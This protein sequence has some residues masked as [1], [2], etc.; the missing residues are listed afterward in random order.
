MNDPFSILGVAET[1]TPD[2]I[3]KKYRRLAQKYH[4]DRNKDVD[5][6]SKFK[7]VNEAYDTLSNDK[8]RQDYL[9][10]R[11]KAETKNRY[12]HSFADDEEESI[13]DIFRKFRDSQQ[14]SKQYATITL[15]Q[16][17]KGAFLKVSG[18]TY[19]VSPGT[20][21]GTKYQVKGKLVEII[22]MAH[23]KFKRSEND[24]LVDVTLSIAEAVLGID[25]ILTHLDNTQLKFKIPSGIQPGQIVRLS[26]KGM[27][28]FDR[29]GAS[30]DLLI[31]CTVSIPKEIGTAQKLFYKSIMSR[32]I[33]TV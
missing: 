2:E 3:K 6:E 21:H 14:N 11:K 13:A 16:A 8:K 26:G 7:E 4:P 24:L 17:Y 33:I 19:Y 15:E 25:A 12:T 22:V 9:N 23:P 29:N 5:A 1:A 27:P 32:D 18:D 28:S 30:G 10:S 20:A 31:R